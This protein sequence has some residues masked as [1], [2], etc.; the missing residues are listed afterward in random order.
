MRVRAGGSSLIAYLTCGSLEQLKLKRPSGEDSI[1]ME[2]SGRYPTRIAPVQL[3]QTVVAWWNAS[4]LL[5]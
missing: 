5:T 3:G 1:R 4:L 2:A